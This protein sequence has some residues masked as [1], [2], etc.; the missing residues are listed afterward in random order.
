[1]ETKKSSSGSFDH[2]VFE[3]FNERIKQGSLGLS[4]LYVV[5]VTP[6][7]DKNMRLIKAYD[8][9]LFNA[10]KNDA[11]NLAAYMMEN[12]DVD[13]VT[14]PTDL[15]NMDLTADCVILLH[16]FTDFDKSHV[17]EQLTENNA[18]LKCFEFH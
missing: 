6:K 2:R 12:M 8:E 14:I 5:I 16:E 3:G 1:M 7:L 10:Q 9:A 18:D 11:H 13:L 15:Y 4:G 17:L